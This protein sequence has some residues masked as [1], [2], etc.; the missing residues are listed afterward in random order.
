MKTDEINGTTRI[1]IAFVTWQLVPDVITFALLL[2]SR[3]A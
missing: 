2:K 3:S 1:F